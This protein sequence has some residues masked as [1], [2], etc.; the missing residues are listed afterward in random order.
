MSLASDF[1]RIL[2]GQV[3]AGDGWEVV[4]DRVLDAA[5]AQVEFTGLDGDSAYMYKLEGYFTASAVCL[6]F[7]RL[8]GDSGSRY[9][10]IVSRLS[11]VYSSNS[12]L[13]TG[14]DLMTGASVAVGESAIIN[15][16]IM[17][18]AAALHVMRSKLSVNI[19]ASGETH[20]STGDWQPASGAPA[21]SSILLDA[22]VFGTGRFAAGSRFVLSRLRAPA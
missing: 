1:A 20:I 7:V 13:A 2:G 19:A 16:V 5:A 10:R 9:D 8:N 4:S 6:P 12:A 22:G 18:Q 17:A 15:V 21:V 3:D 11:S 14:F